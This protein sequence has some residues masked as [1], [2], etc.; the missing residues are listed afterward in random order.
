MA[1]HHIDLRRHFSHQSLAC[2]SESSENFLAGK[3]RRGARGQPTPISRPNQ[4]KLKGSISTSTAV[5]GISCASQYAIAPLRSFVKIE[6]LG[7][8]SKNWKRCSFLS[9]A[10]GAVAG[11][12][13]RT[14]CPSCG[15]KYSDS[16]REKRIAFSRLVSR[17]ITFAREVSGGYA[18]I[19]RKCISR[20]KNEA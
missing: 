3:T 1:R 15:E 13:M 20:S 17:T 12:R 8:F 16:L 11:P 4:S 14:V 5:C 9:R 6:R 7:D 2:C 18:N 19:L 10:R